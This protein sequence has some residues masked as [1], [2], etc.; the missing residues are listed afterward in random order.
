LINKTMTKDGEDQ[1]IVT[2]DKDPGNYQVQLTGASDTQYSILITKE[3][4]DS[5]DL[6]TAREYSLEKS[7]S[8]E[9]EDITLKVTSDKKGLYVKN[10]NDENTSFTFEF[11]STEA[12]DGIDYIPRSIGTM[13]LTKN[14]EVTVGPSDWKTTE[15]LAGIALIQPDSTPGFEVLILILALTII[16][17]LKRKK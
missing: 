7:S 13:G 6:S 4:T 17:S 1:I 10:T 11:K 5:N 8:N 15:E 14:Q 2:P 12:L 3:Y 9:N 16:L